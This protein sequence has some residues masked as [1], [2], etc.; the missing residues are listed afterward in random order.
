MKTQ[1]L[2]STTKGRPSHNTDGPNATEGANG[3]RNERSS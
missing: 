3:E 1:R 2:T